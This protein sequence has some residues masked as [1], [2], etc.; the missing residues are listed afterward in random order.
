MP[1]K[2]FLATLLI[3]AL[4]AAAA[5]GY[6]TR[7][8]PEPREPVE[9]ANKANS[10]CALVARYNPEHVVWQEISFPG[11]Q[12]CGWPGPYYQAAAA[13]AV[14]L[15]DWTTYGYNK[16]SAGPYTPPGPTYACSVTVNFE[17]S[18]PTSVSVTFTGAAACTTQRN[19][20]LAVLKGA[21]ACD[22]SIV[23]CPWSNP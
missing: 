21:M 6:F 20:I 2:R 16:D 12:V 5:P 1:A 3:A 13:A 18:T 19:R 17:P 4:P 9:V 14:G 11:L 10:T 22:V 23:P 7:E 8:A 15:P